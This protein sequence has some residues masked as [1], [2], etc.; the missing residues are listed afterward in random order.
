MG[1]IYGIMDIGVKALRAQQLALEVTSHNIANAD[2]PGYTR[3]YAVME[4]TSPSSAG[5][6][7]FLG[8]GV[9][10]TAIERVYDSFTSAQ[11]NMETQSYGDAAAKYATLQTVEPVFNE[12]AN[13]GLGNALSEFFN[14]WESLST[15]PAGILERQAV[16]EKGEQMAVALRGA[17]NSLNLVREQ[18]NQAISQTVD[19]INA[20]TAEIASLNQEIYTLESAGT[21][22]NDIRDRRD[23]SIEQ[24]AE[25]IG[26]STFETDNGMVTVAIQGGPVLVESGRQNSIAADVA[27]GS[28]VLN[29]AGSGGKLD[30]TGLVRSGRLGG[31]VSARDNHV[32]AY[33]DAIDDLAAAVVVEVNKLHFKGY[34]LDG[35]TNNLFF[36]APSALTGADPKNTGGASINGGSITDPSQLTSDEY[37]IRFTTPASYDV[38][39]VITGT[40]VVSGAAYT[41]GGNITDVPGMTVAISDGGTGPAAGDRFSV[42][43][44]KE[45]LTATISL[46]SAVTAA[47][48]KIAAALEDPVLVSGPG[49]NRNA[50]AISALQ[51]SDIVNGG[52]AS[53]MEFYA[54]LVGG[55][56]HD[57]EQ[58]GREEKF[59]DASLRQLVGLRDA[60]SGVSIDEEMVNLIKFQNGYAA[61]ARL[62]KVGTEL[63]DIL[64]NLGR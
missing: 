10:V 9:D 53:V 54:A 31:L 18:T 3:Q 1:N 17:R 40:A 57:L 55:V 51:H 26:I 60:V 47:P 4:T 42:G 46:A 25:K 50:L 39:N 27:G 29:F 59:H 52:S 5:P 36:E 41:S 8:T 63:M 58:A 15:N 28:R 35:S 61:G 32:Q 62:I 34:G 16:I 43:I 6:A 37:E 23:H 12:S 56:G 22:A 20:L 49:D 38:I 45:A 33:M 24:L 7:G 14:A 19:Q 30:I 2:T 21:E 11:I 13:A 44:D 64:V 48:D